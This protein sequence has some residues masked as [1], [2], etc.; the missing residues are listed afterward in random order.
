MT[1]AASARPVI[2]RLVAAAAIL[3]LAC[4]VAVAA[5]PGADAAN[6]ATTTVRITSIQPTSGDLL[7]AQE[8]AVVRGTVSRNLVGER[9]VLQREVDG[10]WVSTRA[11]TTVR[12]DA[13]Y[14]LRFTVRGMG[15]ARYRVRFEGTRAKAPSRGIRAATTWR[16]ISLVPHVTG[17]NLTKGEANVAGIHHTRVLRARGVDGGS[18]DRG[19]LALSGRCDSI[20]AVIGVSD[21][22]D[23]GFVTEFS[24]SLD[25]EQVL[26]GATV[27]AGS[28]AVV[29]LRTAGS[30]ELGLEAA[31][32]AATGTHRGAAVWAE[33][34]ALCRARPLS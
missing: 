4:A 13:T 23:P 34:R 24:L 33:P 2:V 30:E 11:S 1:E 18:P 14:R 31:Y 20:V 16:W 25:G 5:A 7:V 15:D 28:S 17:G 32:P 21:A 9:L 10:R 6:R 12:A 8:A 29:A 19:T 27:A 26:T 22:S 3:A